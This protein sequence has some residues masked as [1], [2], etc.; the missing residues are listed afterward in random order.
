MEILLV[1]DM[2]DVYNKGRHM[3][4]IKWLLWSPVLLIIL[5]VFTTEI[6]KAYW[7]YKVKELCNKDGGVTVF[8]TVNLT[9]DQYEKHD[10]NRGM[11][12]VFPKRM[13]RPHHDFYITRTVEI[14]KESNPYVARIENVFV[15]KS[16]EQQLGNMVHYS[17]K[18]GDFPTGFHPS[19]FSCLKMPNIEFGLEKKVFLITSDL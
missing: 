16:D 14:I 18:G 6:H 5:G 12:S 3:K 11:I 4:I 13:S 19:N 2:S 1:T 17:R 15:R 10:G 8:E 7:D 9:Q